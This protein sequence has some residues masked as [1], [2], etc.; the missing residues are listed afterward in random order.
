MGQKI[1]GILLRSSILLLIAVLPL[2]GV[3]AGEL[4]AHPGY[5]DSV[6][7]ERY[8]LSREIIIMPVMPAEVAPNPN[9][10][11]TDKITRDIQRRYDDQFGRTLGEQIV[12]VPERFYDKQLT[13]G[14][15]VTDDVYLQKQRQFGA[16][17]FRRVMEY[18]VDSYLRGT[19][20]A[21]PVYDLK[22]KLGDMNVG[23]TPSF[24]LKF[25]YSL[26]GNFLE[27]NIINPYKI[28][29]K[30][31]LENFGKRDV[32]SAVSYPVT[33]SVTFVADHH[34][35]Y[36]AQ[37]ISFVKQLT[38]R[39]ATSLTDS[40]SDLEHKGIIGFSWID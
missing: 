13:P 36:H 32:V 31:T 27:T 8:E 1:S 6:E 37:T 4:D 23:V 14:L 28:T 24:K 15:F 17:V 26:A 29:A 3:W 11:F 34:N 10:V 25:K 40:R 38:P 30:V 5:L 19:P 9:R 33:K 2:F 35:E 18:Q 12:T 7:G 39:T 22:Q 16:Y 21:R 20:A